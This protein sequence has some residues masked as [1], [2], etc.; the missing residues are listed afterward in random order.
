MWAVL[1][2]VHGTPVV[3]IKWKFDNNASDVVD[4]QAVLRGR[5][6]SYGE[7]AGAD[8]EQVLRRS[9]FA[10]TRHAT[11]TAKAQHQVANLVANQ[12]K[13]EHE[14][15]VLDQRFILTSA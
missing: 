14:N 11:G 6:L 12:D 10:L 4:S 13:G 15:S 2:T 9:V 3:L 1:E 8:E 7:A 5:V